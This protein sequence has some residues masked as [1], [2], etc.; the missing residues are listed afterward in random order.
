LTGGNNRWAVVSTAV[1]KITGI[2][3]LY[4]VFKGKAET[5]I[6]FFDYWMFTK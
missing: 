5:D 4:F 2:H 1:S 6:A 3:D